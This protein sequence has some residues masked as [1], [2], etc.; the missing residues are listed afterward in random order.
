M[1]KKR[2][3]KANLKRSSPSHSQA[4]VIG[5]CEWIIHLANYRFFFFCLH[6]TSTCWHS[7]LHSR[8]L[9]LRK[10]T[11]CILRKWASTTP[12]KKGK[13]YYLLTPPIFAFWLDFVF[14]PLPRISILKKERVYTQNQFID[15]I[16]SIEEK[17][18]NYMKLIWN[19]N[20]IEQRV[21]VRATRHLLKSGI[22]RAGTVLNF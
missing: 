7:H 15:Y 6:S 1:G 14:S 8:F 3:S 18:N 2:H 5:K 12:A 21:G 16:V 17:S 9:S 19:Q 22:R 10:I 13:N 20:R 4:G 11:Q